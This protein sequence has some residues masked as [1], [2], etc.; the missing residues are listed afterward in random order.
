M[1]K[2]MSLSNLPIGTMKNLVINDIP[3]ALCNVSGIIYALS[4]LCTHNRCSLAGDGFMDHGVITCGCH[5]AQFDVKTGK[6]LALP[7]TKDLKT[8]KTE[9]K[10]GDIYIDL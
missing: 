2:A 8:Y 10:D 5:G 6:A 7:A 4:D 1:K 9:I 3:I